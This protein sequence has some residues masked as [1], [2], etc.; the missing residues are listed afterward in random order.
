MPNTIEK[1]LQFKRNS[2]ICENYTKALEKM[3]AIS[4][5]LADGEVVLIRYYDTMETVDGEHPIKTLTAY[6]QEIE[7]TVDSVVTQDDKLEKNL[8][9]TKQHGTKEAG[10]VFSAGTSI[11]SMLRTLLS[12]TVEPSNTEVETI[13]LSLQPKFSST[14]NYY[15]GS[16]TLTSVTATAKRIIIYHN[17]ELVDGN[18]GDFMKAETV[19]SGYTFN[20]I[21]ASISGGAYASA[22]TFTNTNSNSVTWTLD[23]PITISGFDGIPFNC[24][25]SG[26]VTND[27]EITRYS[28]DSNDEVRYT[29][30]FS[31][32]T[33]KAYSSV[34][35]DTTYRMYF[36]WGDFAHGYP[37]KP[38]D[39]EVT[40][41]FTID[42]VNKYE[43]DKKNQNVSGVSWSVSD[44][45]HNDADKRPVIG[46]K[47]PYMLLPNKDGV[48]NNISQIKV[49]YKDSG[50]MYDGFET[51][52]KLVSNAQYTNPNH[53]N[54]DITYILFL[55]ENPLNEDSPIKNGTFSKQ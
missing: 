19:P 10:Y 27:E 51:Y 44:P 17:V 7:D 35:Q 47:Y 42:N 1:T 8:K 25:V 5:K 40:P 20:L 33:N 22:T 39:S 37:T 18:Y 21:A 53:S 14:V 2:N 6:R 16:K 11:E 29:H 48:F 12:E 15:G 24:V 52:L 36:G 50:N 30:V 4:N 26:N 28:Y 31:G 41:L 9:L 32:G 55:P 43:S 49:L 54:E 34:T 13:S 38:N 23:P 45:Y 3:R 46:G